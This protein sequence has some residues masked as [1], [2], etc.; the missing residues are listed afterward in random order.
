[1][2]THQNA[3]KLNYIINQA[4]DAEL[5][6]DRVVSHEQVM[7]LRDDYLKSKI[8]KQLHQIMNSADV[9]NRARQQLPDL[10]VRLQWSNSM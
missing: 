8:K 3:L 5:N 10:L 9:T 4:G 6:L 7:Q 1:M 2:I